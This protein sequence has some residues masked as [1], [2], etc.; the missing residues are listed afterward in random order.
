M[1][2]NGDGDAD[3]ASTLGP[4]VAA[5]NNRPR[6]YRL[7]PTARLSKSTTPQPTISTGYL[8]FNTAM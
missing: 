6:R 5:N 1:R 2:F 8:T 7:P 4:T 3:S